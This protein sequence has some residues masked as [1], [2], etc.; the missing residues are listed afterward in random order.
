MKI[1]YFIKLRTPQTGGQTIFFG[2]IKNIIIFY[3][4]QCTFLTCPRYNT[5]KY[6]NLFWLL[7]LMFFHKYLPYYNHISNFHR[8][9]YINFFWFIGANALNLVMKYHRRIN[10]SDDMKNFA[11]YPNLKNWKMQVANFITDPR[12]INLPK[13]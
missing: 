10:N 1:T 6:P 12:E 7:N 5:L 11:F 13:K 8:P 4:G 3:I 2:K 9:P